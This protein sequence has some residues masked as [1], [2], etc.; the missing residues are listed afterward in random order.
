MPALLLP[1]VVAGD[2]SAQDQAAPLPGAQGEP[3]VPEKAGKVLVARRLRGEAPRIDGVLDDIA[4][5]RADSLDDLV[6]WE[7]DNMA[8]VSE[9]TVVRILYD[10]RYLYVALHAFDREPHAITTGLGRRDDAPASDEFAIGFDPRHDH[11]TGYTFQVNVSGVREDYDFA[12]DT[13]SDLD[14]NAVWEARTAR[15]AD[16]WTA[17]FRIPFSQMR[18]SVSDGPPVWG[19]DMR[20]VI[21]RKGEIAQWVGRPRGQQGQVSRWGHLM[22]EEALAPPRRLEVTP[23][24]LARRADQ[25]TD[26]AEYRMQAGADM[27]LGLGSGSTLSATVLP[28]FGQVEADPAVLNLTVF[29]TFFPERRPFFLEDGNTFVPP[30]GLFRLFH[31]RRIGRRPSHVPI[32]AGETLLDQPDETTLLGAAKVTGRTGAWTYGVLS[33]ATEAERA[34][35]ERIAGESGETEQVRR[36]IEPAAFYNAARI[37]RN[38]GRTSNVGLLTTAVVRDGFP[39]AYTG[40]ID[41]SLRWDSNRWY[42]NGHWAA[43]RAPRGDRLK[44]DLGGVTNVG[45]TAKHYSVWAH[46]DHFGPDF[47]ITDMG[48]LATRTNRTFVDGGFGLSQPDPW[49]VFR[50]MSSYLA[51]GQGWN[52]DGLVFERFASGGI[53]TRLRNFW[54]VEV[55]GGYGWERLDDLDTRGGPPILRPGQ[56]AVGGFIATDSRKT[57]RASLFTRANWDTVGGSGL[58]LNPEL[59]LSPSARVQTTV[60]VRYRRNHETA[61]WIRNLDADGDGATDHVYGALESRVVDITMRGTLALHPDLTFELFMQPFVAVGDYSDFKRLARPRSFEF[62]PVALT[63]NP[64]FNRKSLRGNAVLRWEYRPGSTLFLVWNVVGS[65]LSRPGEFSFSRDIADAFGVKRDN[66]F[67]LKASYWLSW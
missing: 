37:Q 38:I 46:G 28:D 9:R 47:S 51:Y 62:E 60:G 55:F 45:Y 48:F 25:Q 54:L 39:S 67:M 36:L 29:E 23:F 5:T 10:D 44:T 22:F 11:Q 42:W 14:Y 2:S 8:P 21:H 13:R 33:A 15:T 7:P 66:I 19:M 30:Y 27:R 1:C 12:D 43:S 16:G 17:E 58:Q 32:P 40:G 57:W 18:F 6:Q 49:W 24:T 31:S 50:N 61:Q 3:N 4:W 41:Y 53:N 26:P 63:F 35:V 56:R 64:D 65:D 59:R 52:R 20:R 34:L